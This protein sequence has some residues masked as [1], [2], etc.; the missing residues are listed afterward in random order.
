M[1]ILG[2]LKN[3]IAWKRI[4]ASP[5]I[6][7]VKVMFAVLGTVFALSFAVASAGAASRPPGMFEEYCD[8]T[9]MRMCLR[10]A[11][12]Y[13]CA[14]YSEWALQ[15]KRQRACEMAAYETVRIL[16]LDLSPLK[17]GETNPVFFKKRLGTILAIPTVYTYLSEIP[18]EVEKAIQSGTRFKLWEYTRKF[19]LDDSA[20]SE[21]IAL[22]FQDTNS[23]RI[24]TK[25]ARIGGKSVSPELLEVWEKAIDALHPERFRGP[26]GADYATVVRPYP[27]VDTEWLHEGFYHFYFVAHLAHS[28]VKRRHSESA[29]FFLPFLTNALYE[30]YE[31]PRED[32]LSD[33]K[34]FDTKGKYAYKTADLYSGYVGSLWALGH[35]EEAHGYAIFAKSISTSPT[36]AMKEH[37]SWSPKRPKGSAQASSHWPK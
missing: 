35:Y 27:N 5:H 36:E 22:L 18:L 13:K 4:S 12:V 24:F 10:A 31:L 34:P 6:L 26:K 17:D 32:L 1:L 25:Y 29:A 9:G 28:L 11:L 14:Q 3:S 21:W 2:R 15:T 33:P 37:Y 16:D 19:T 23:N 8:G 30:F 7:P 20:A